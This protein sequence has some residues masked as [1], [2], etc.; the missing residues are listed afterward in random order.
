MMEIYPYNERGDCEG[1][2]RFF[3]WAYDFWYSY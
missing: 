2:N 3:Y 1:N